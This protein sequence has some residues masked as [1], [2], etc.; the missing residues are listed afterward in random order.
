[1]KNL[2]LEICTMTEM[3]LELIQQWKL[4]HYITIWRLEGKATRFGN[5]RD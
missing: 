2:L 1:M 3:V 4:L 5:S